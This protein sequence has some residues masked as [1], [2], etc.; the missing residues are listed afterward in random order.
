MISNSRHVP[1]AKKRRLIKEVN[2]KCPFPGCEV[3]YLE[4]HH[5]DPPW[6][7]GHV[8]NES[9]MI[10]LCATHHHNADDIHVDLMRKMKASPNLGIVQG[11]FQ[12]TR[13]RTVIYL[14]DNRIS[15]LNVL[16]HN[17]V[18]LIWFT[19]SEDGHQLLNLRFIDLGGEIHEI[20]SENVWMVDPNEFLKYLDSPPNGKKLRI[21][22]KD[23]SS[24]NLEQ[25][26]NQENTDILNIHISFEMKSIRTKIV[27]DKEGQKT[28]ELQFGRVHLSNVDL[29]GTLG[30][31][32][33]S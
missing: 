18:D 26:I 27:K 1:A 17:G 8:H 19:E 16:K 5:F 25:K 11:K 12:V 32:Y 14:G 23:G 30:I 13:K 3:P 2:Y 20:I 33:N 15:S 29:D 4:I 21:E 6:R 28:N 9:G 22:F 24:F 7:E 31:E 10:A